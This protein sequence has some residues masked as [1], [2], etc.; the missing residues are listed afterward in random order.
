[1]ACV[2]DDVRG[3]GRTLVR[4][5]AAADL[6]ALSRLLVQLYAFELPGMLRGD[7][8]VQRQLARRLLSSTPLGHRYVLVRHGAIV[9]MGS[10]ATQDAPRPSTP[11]GVMLAFPSVM[12]VRGAL[13]S[14][15][16]VLRGLLTVAAPPTADEAQ[17]HSV[18]IDA[19]S[20]GEGLGALLM[21]HLER[22]AARA[23]KRRVVLQVIA[24]N[25][26]ARRFYRSRGFVEDGPAHGRRRS[27]LAYPSVLMHKDLASEHR[28]PA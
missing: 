17:I 22:E 13:A 19:D 28:T 9:G 24:A 2:T 26:A 4:A 23:G 11:P 6:D 8:G 16:G 10:F 25:G 20:R 7:V 5:A 12:G 18:V 15:A 1:V 14:Y 21:E 27:A 3:C